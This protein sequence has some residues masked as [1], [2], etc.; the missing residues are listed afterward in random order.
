MA[1]RY[2]IRS[3]FWCTTDVAM[4]VAIPLMTFRLARTYGMLTWPLLMFI[5]V[6][7]WIG[8]RDYANFVQLGRRHRALQEKRRHITVEMRNN[9]KEQLAQPPG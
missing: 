4:I 5:V 6:P 3:L 8:P 2:S 9:N 1:P 7:I